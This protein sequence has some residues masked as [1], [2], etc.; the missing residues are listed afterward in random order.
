[1]SHACWQ[2]YRS[3]IAAEVPQ[4]VDVVQEA[5]A[6]EYEVTE[7]ASAEQQNEE[8][9]RHLTTENG[10]LNERAWLSLL[11]QSVVEVG[12]RG[13]HSLVAEVDEIGPA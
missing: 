7:A 3:A 2:R 6:P 5:E 4:E 9:G 13:I 11:D 10:K 1:M 8:K 12:R